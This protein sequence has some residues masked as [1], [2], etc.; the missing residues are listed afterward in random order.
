MSKPL[1]RQVAFAC[2]SYHLS[3]EE[4]AKKKAAGPT[5][6]G[7]PKILD[8]G[9]HVKAKLLPE[10]F[11]CILTPKT[12]MAAC[13]ARRKPSVFVKHP[14]LQ[15]RQEDHEDRWHPPR[16]CEHSRKLTNT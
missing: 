11:Q 6:F 7:K 16:R 8:E 1:S 4:P 3:G 10:E 5:T 13:A 12:P 9:E 2:L 15:P 14:A